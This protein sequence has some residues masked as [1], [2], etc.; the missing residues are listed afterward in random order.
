VSY[1]AG[2]LHRPADGLISGVGIAGP[3]LAHWLARRGHRPVL[4]E[5]TDGLPSGGHAVDIRGT[6]LEVIERMVLDAEVRAS[7]ARS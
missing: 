5:H 3:A 2:H 4:I 6:A 1:G 7:C